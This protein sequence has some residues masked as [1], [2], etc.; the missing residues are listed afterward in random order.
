MIE[1]RRPLEWS[2]R[3]VENDIPIATDDG[4]SLHQAERRPAPKGLQAP[5]AEGKGGNGINSLGKQPLVPRTETSFETSTRITCRCGAAATIHPLP[6]PAPPIPLDRVQ[7]R[8]HLVGPVDG[9]VEEG[10]IELSER[11]A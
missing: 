6:S 4:A 5:A 2:D 10:L 11:D 7:M 9:D 1:G 3:A 8:V